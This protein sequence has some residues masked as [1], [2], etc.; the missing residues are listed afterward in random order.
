MLSLIAGTAGIIGVAPNCAGRRGSRL[1]LLDLES[2]TCY[3]YKENAPKS[4]ALC[5][6]R[7]LER[8]YVGHRNGYLSVV[9]LRTNDTNSFAT[10]R[11]SSAGSLTKV[12]VMADGNQILAKHSFGSCFLWDLRMLGQERNGSVSPVLHLKVPKH[13]IH[14]TKSSRCNGVALDPTQSIAISPFVN[15]Q[16]E[17]ACLAFWSTSS[18]TFIGYRK[19]ELQQSIESNATETKQAHTGSGMSLCE[20]SSTLTPGWKPFSSSVDGDMVEPNHDSWGLWFKFGSSIGARTKVPNFVSSIHHV[21][22]PG[23]LM[24]SETRH[25]VLN[26]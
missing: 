3:N 18:G 16:D 6:E 14:T 13:V 12:M 20:L 5:I 23:R 11:D 4:D 1:V 9:D 26:D 24:D 2:E 19:L 21:T 8:F 22:F 15:K 10:T 17:Q 7:S 25:Q